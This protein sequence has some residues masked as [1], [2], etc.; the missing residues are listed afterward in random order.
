MCSE[1]LLYQLQTLVHLILA[2]IYVGKFKNLTTEGP[3]CNGRLWLS[4][5]H[6]L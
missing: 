4:V 3:C 5:L 1:L 6:E 2:D